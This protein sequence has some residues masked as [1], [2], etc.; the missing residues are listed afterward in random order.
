M[1][2]KNEKARKQVSVNLDEVRE[3]LE[4]V[5]L[6]G[7]A[8]TNVISALSTQQQALHALGHT[9]HKFGPK[10]RDFIS[11]AQEAVLSPNPETRR[12]AQAIRNYLQLAPPPTEEDCQC[13]VCTMIRLLS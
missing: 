5:E 13:P 8:Q 7:E 3:L 9:I 1:S 11:W 6:L 10:L 12:L 2:R 4:A